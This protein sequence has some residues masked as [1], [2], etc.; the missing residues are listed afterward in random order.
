[1]GALNWA[2]M[3]PRDA[4]LSDSYTSDRC[5][6]SSLDLPLQPG[7]F[8]LRVSEANEVSISSKRVDI[9]SECIEKQISSKF[10]YEHGYE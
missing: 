8:L 1:M 3:M 9:T 2:L 7:R 6:Y 10:H 5:P 4:S